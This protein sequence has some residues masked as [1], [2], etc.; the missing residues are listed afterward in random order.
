MA[1]ILSTEDVTVF[2]GPAKIS[3]DLDFGPT[4][5]RGSKIFIGGLNPNS[6]T[7]DETIYYGDL[8]INNDSNSIEY[9]SIYTYQN[10]S[11]VNTWVKITN[12]IP[13]FY[14][15]KSLSEFSVGETTIN[16]PLVD[17]TY[18]DYTGE[19]TTDSFI[20]QHSLVNTANPTV[21]NLSISG[22]TQSGGI[23][24]LQ[25]SVKA[26]EYNGEAW[27]DVTGQRSVHLF[28]SVV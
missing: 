10:V 1:N 11:S 7:F 13:N 25:L 6:D 23:Q 26:T 28:I 2:G 4:G 24:I 3:L 16:I 9:R 14:S 5:Q 18:S 12:L 17:L 19:L 22:I 15:R 20:I 21:S 8:Y 27:I